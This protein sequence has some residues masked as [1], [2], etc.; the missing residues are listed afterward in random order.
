MFLP[1]ISPGKAIESVYFGVH[2][3]RGP[4]LWLSSF[5]WEVQMVLCRDAH[6]LLVTSASSADT[7]LS[8]PGTCAACC[9]HPRDIPCDYPEYLFHFSDTS[10]MSF[11]LGAETLIG[12]VS[13]SKEATW[14]SFEEFPGRVTSLRLWKGLSDLVASSCALPQTQAFER[15]TACFPWDCQRCG[16]ALITMV[17]NARASQ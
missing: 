2:G 11:I 4:L 6:I 7:Y 17:E 15:Q 10:A 16:P 13:I 8:E 1:N 5:R 9:S 14:E 12:P 3:T